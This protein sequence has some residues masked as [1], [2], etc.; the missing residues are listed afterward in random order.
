MVEWLHDMFFDFSDV[1]Y[2]QVAVAYKYAPQPCKDYA[3]EYFIGQM[4]LNHVVD[5][6]YFDAKEKFKHAFF[7][8][9]YIRERAPMELLYSCLR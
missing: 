5:Q 3:G 1:V 9:A 7:A 8:A 6:H 4:K 2:E